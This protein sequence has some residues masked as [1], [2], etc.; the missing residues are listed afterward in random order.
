MSD[1]GI[2]KLY[3]R[4][5]TLI[6]LPFSYCPGC[7]HGVFH[8]LIAQAIDDLQIRERTIGIAPVGCAVRMWN[9]FDCDM[10][11]SLH[12]R[13]P[14]VATG[15]K[16]SL[17]DRVVWMYTGDGDLA[18]IGMGEI[19]H[20]A[21]RG[22]R[23]SVFFLNNCCFGATGGQMAP[24]TLIGQIT[25]TTPQ[26]RDAQ[27]VG[28]PIRVSELLASLEG[29]AYIERVSLT[30]PSAIRQAQRAVRKALQVQIESKGFSL[31]EALGMCPTNL[32]L[33]PAESVAWVE[34][35]AM[36]HYPLGVLKT[37]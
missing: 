22:E 24:T 3:G 37:P 21:A 33:S 17:P 4:P 13:G 11:Q 15:L 27:S 7:S 34:E 29:P 26:G 9:H 10:S 1:T 23:F 18:A 20:A 5:A 6:G 25:T 30:N 32:H 36:Q 28:Y 31:V 19:I 12:G 35:K 14:A 2:R 16:R 8:R